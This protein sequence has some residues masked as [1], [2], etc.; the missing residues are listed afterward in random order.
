MSG[1]HH[2]QRVQKGM[3]CSAGT[4]EKLD[5]FEKKRSVIIYAVFL[6]GPAMPKEAWK[7]WELEELVSSEV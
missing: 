5:I 2:R 1:A 6:E 4:D 7:W 3:G